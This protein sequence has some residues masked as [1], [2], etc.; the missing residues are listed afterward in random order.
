MDVQVAEV[1]NPEATV[2]TAG[3]LPEAADVQAAASA[4]AAIPAVQDRVE[5]E[6]AVDAPAGTEG[7]KRAVLSWPFKANR[8]LQTRRARIRIKPAATILTAI[9]RNALTKTN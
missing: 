6:L 7:V 8:R 9:A 5:Q 2:P 3:G 1:N 4:V